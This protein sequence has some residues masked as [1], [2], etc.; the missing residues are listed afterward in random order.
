[1]AIREPERYRRR[2]KAQLGDLVGTI[3]LPEIEKQALESRFI[4]RVLWAEKRATDARRAYYGLRLT[5]ILGGVLVPSLVSLNIGETGAQV[6]RWITFGV[7]LL[8]AMA[9][10]TEEF[11][12]FGDRWR[13]YRQTAELLKEEGWEFFQRTGDYRNRTHA[14]CFPTFARR[15]ERLVHEDVEKF[16]TQVVYDKRDPGLQM[17]KPA[18][19]AGQPDPT[20]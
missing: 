5:A 15:V 16:V 12:H 18:D 11:F 4:D 20:S 19:G 1:M 14:E 7:S 2:L 6:V 17:R 13:H 8:V 3:E 10:A 9:I